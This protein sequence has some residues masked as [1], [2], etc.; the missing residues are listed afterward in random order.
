MT[1]ILHKVHSAINVVEVKFQWVK[2]V[3]DWTHSGHGYFAG[4][5]VTKS[6][7]LERKVDRFKSTR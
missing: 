6:C 2:Y 3:T 1:D 7:Q 5:A 4:I